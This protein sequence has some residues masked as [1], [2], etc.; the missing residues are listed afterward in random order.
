MPTSTLILPGGITENILQQSTGIFGSFAPIV[1][2]ILGLLTFFFVSR[3]FI[4]I[5]LDRREQARIDR[6]NYESAMSKALTTLGV[7]KPE[8]KAIEGEI[9]KNKSAQKAILLR[10]NFEK[11]ISGRD[12]ISTKTK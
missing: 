2:M 3:V 9:A 1:Y 4:N 8:A 10:A 11:V 7:A 5:M 12:R 6:E